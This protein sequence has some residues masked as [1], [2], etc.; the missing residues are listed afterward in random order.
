VEAINEIFKI[1]QGN[2]R[3]INRIFDQIQRI[4][5]INNLSNISEELVDAAKNA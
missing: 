3:L 2:F 4:K 5:E 1:T